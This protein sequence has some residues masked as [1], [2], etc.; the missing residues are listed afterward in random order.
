[1]SNLLI[2]TIY[3]DIFYLGEIM[4]NK[5]KFKYLFMI[6]IFIFI[7]G[8]VKRTLQNDTFYT[9]KI[10]ELIIN[11]G[12]DML[13]HFSW[14]QNLAYT[15]PHWLYDVFIYLIFHFTGYR[16]LYISSMIL[17]F[18][19][20]LIVFKVNLKNTNNYTFSALGVLLC[21]IALSGYATA[22]AQLVSFILFALEIYFI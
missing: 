11:N 5:K 22:R 13:D 6:W 18:I 4:K 17:L 8:L 15:Y 19:V 21:A 14:H 1:M 10:G 7:I 20:L 12:I 2:I 9:I 3:Y 16:G